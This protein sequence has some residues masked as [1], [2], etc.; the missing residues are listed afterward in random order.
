MQASISNLD[1]TVREFKV[2]KGASEMTSEEQFYN[3]RI[4]EVRNL[5]VGSSITDYVS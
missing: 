4:Q 5:L 3:E 2:F 1:L